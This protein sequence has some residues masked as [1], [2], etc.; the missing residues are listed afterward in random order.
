M[1]ELQLLPYFC[2][3]SINSYIKSPTA[4]I[5]NINGPVRAI[6]SWVGAND[7]PLSQVDL[8]SYEQK[9]ELTNYKRSRSLPGGL[10]YNNFDVSIFITLHEGVFYQLFVRL[11]SA[12]TFEPISGNIDVPLGKY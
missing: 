5:A 8:I 7:A 11:S 10:F 1:L 4:F 12:T 2:G 6:R 9:E 3:R